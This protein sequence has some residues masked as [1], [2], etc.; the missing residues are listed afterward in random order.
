M[1]LVWPQLVGVDIA[2]NHP[3]AYGNKRAAILAI[4]PFFA[5]NGG[6]LVASKLNA[7]R[8]MQSAAAGETEEDDFAAWIRGHTHRCG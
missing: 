2:R 4:A 3:F 6:R 7:T 1:S 8:F 5:L